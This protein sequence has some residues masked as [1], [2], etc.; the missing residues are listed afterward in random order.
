M[1]KDDFMENLPLV[2]NYTLF[3]IDKTKVTRGLNVILQSYNNAVD[4]GIDAKD[5]LLDI[6]K[7]PT[8]W[9]NVL[10]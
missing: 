9:K 10:A 4:V 5:L 3:N 8:L 1:P 6:T 2:N 7:L